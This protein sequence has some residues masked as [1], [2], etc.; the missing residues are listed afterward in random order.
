MAKGIIAA[1]HELTVQAAEMVLAD[2][3]NAFDAAIAAFYAACVAEPVLASPGGGGF[4]LAKCGNTRPVL[5]DF[6]VQTPTCLGKPEMDFF[7]IVADFGETQQEFHIGHASVAVPG[8]MRGLFNVH[9]DLASMPMQELVRPAIDFARQGIRI[10]SFQAFIFD[11]VKPIFVHS[12]SVKNNFSGK[13]NRDVL[14]VEGDVFQPSKMA[15]TLEAIAHETERLFYEGEIATDII[16]ASIESGGLL[17]KN[18]LLSYQC[19]KRKALG[20]SY[21][22]SQLFT[23][24]PPSSGGIL[25]AFALKLLESSGAEPDAFGSVASLI[26]IARA[27]DLTQKVR[28]DQAFK[29]ENLHALLDRELLDKYAAQIKDHAQSYRGT[30]HISIID[31]QGNMAGLSLSNGEGCGY[32]LSDTGIM[33]NNMLGEQD[34]NPHGFF[35]WETS[36]RMTSMMAPSLMLLDDGRHV[37]TGSGGSNRI[38]SALLQVIINLID[39]GMPL[40]EAVMSPRLHMEDGLL[41]IESQ[42]DAGVIEEIKAEFSNHQIWSKPNL[43]FGGAHSVMQDGENYYGAGDGRRGG[44]SKLVV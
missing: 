28:V 37:V 38:R 31:K 9:K 42:F 4:M 15:N 29:N 22:N 44:I 3:G 13:N 34:L 27:M 30:T 39:H 17:S 11:V 25:I 26:K 2:G 41:N 10:N 36:Q 8:V 32:M 23:N 21:R 1:G 6:F 16:K 14:L 33:L 19:I 43:F 5:Y 35:Q 12:E 40:D 20:F 24:P 18:D 7:P